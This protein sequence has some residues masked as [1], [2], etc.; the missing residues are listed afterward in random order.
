MTTPIHRGLKAVLLSGVTSCI[1]GFLLIT[2][3]LLFEFRLDIRTLAFTG[4]VMLTL[5]PLFYLMSCIAM[6]PLLLALN[7]SKSLRSLYNIKTEKMA[8]LISFCI[9]VIYMLGIMLLLRVFI[10]VRDASQIAYIIGAGA[11][12]SGAICYLRHTHHKIAEQAAP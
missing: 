7:Y 3:V 1:S 2:L 10:Q 12:C 11:G 4:I 9:G 6:I 5:I 8:I